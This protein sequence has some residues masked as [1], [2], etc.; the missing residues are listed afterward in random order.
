VKNAWRARSLLNMNK[1]L[2]V[3]LDSVYGVLFDSRPE[4]DAYWLASGSGGL[5]LEEIYSG[6]TRPGF[7][8]PSGQPL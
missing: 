7:L 4:D 1:V 6:Q 2:A 3:K 8:S 5:E